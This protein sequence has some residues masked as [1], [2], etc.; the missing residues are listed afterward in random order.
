MREFCDQLLKAAAPESAIAALS[1]ARG[2]RQPCSLP[3]KLLEHLGEA[4]K[5]GSSSERAGLML[6]SQLHQHPAL[7]PAELTQSAAAGI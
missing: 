5:S 2:L 1:V 7:V 3:H 4:I 6:M